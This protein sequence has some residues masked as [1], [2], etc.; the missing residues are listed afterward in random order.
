[1]L[2]WALAD[3]GAERLITFTLVGPDGETIRQRMKHARS[4]LVALGQEV[5]WAWSAEPNP[6]GTGN[7]VHALQRGSRPIPKR[8]LSRVADG[9][10][11]GSVTDIRRIRGGLDRVSRYPLKSLAAFAYTTKLAG[12]LG[13]F[14]SYLELNG[15]RSFLHTSRGFFGGPR[16]AVVAAAIG[17]RYPGPPEWDLLRADEADGLAQRAHD[18]SVIRHRLGAA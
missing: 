6:A 9:V 10:G 5:E 15:G 7:H 17:A 13:Q 4:D 11:F 1:V 8:L 14:E 2:A 16:R 18:W 3:A 12:D